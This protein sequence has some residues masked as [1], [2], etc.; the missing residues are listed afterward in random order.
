MGITSEDDTLNTY[1]QLVGCGE[2]CEP[3][4]LW[5]I[6]DIWESLPYSNQ[7][8]FSAYFGIV[9]SS[10]ARMSIPT[11]LEDASGHHCEVPICAII[12][13]DGDQCKR[14]WKPQC[15][16]SKWPEEVG[17]GQ[18]GEGCVPLGCYAWGLLHPNCYQEVTQ[19]GRGDGAH[20]GHV[21]C[22]Y[23]TYYGDQDPGGHNNY[24]DTSRRQA[25]VG[26]HY[27]LYGVEVYINYSYHHDYD[28]AKQHRVQWDP[29]GSRQRRRLGVKSHL[30]EGG[31]D[32]RIP[33][34][35]YGLDPSSSWAWLA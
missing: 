3:Q 29:G 4:A 5:D 22:I 30:K 32:V 1:S 35:L 13:A 14:E 18:N 10:S 21:C 26:H 31:R 12:Q 20:A 25:F 24:L 11:I 34:C 17:S 19:G 23:Y 6:G 2:A 27:Y 15:C 28:H 8:T 16:L 9:D 33:P 7:R